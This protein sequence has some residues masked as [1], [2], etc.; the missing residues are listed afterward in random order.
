M[1]LA[2][3]GAANPVGLSAQ[4]GFLFVDSAPSD[5]DLVTALV[6]DNALTDPSVIRSRTVEVSFDLLPDDVAADGAPTTLELNLFSD[7]FLTALID[8]IDGDTYIGHLN[9][10]DDSLL[11]LVTTDDVM[12]GSVTTGS[13][14][15]QIR[16]AGNGIHMV[17]EVNT[18]AL[19]AENPP[20][21]VELTEE[22]LAAD[23]GVQEDVDNVA[24]HSPSQILLP[25]LNLSE[26]VVQMPRVTH[27]AAA[28]QSPRGVEPERQTPTPDRLLRHGGAPWGE[29]IL[30]IAETE[31]EAVVEPD[32]VTDDLR[33]KAISTIA[34]QVAGHRPTLPP[35]SAT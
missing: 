18:A 12:I 35:A 3:F 20:V 24:V 28:A 2:V 26:D 7:V 21:P 10:Y 27:A 5:S 17:R 13:A 25:A 9:G 19:P 15:Y 1:S 23:P 16:Y 4:E 34:G 22:E 31:A 8:E 33:R 11:V 29:E 6:R 30:D 14:Q 32:G